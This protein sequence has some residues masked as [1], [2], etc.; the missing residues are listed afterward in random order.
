ME[1][2]RGDVSLRNKQSERSEGDADYAERKRR[3]T[4]TDSLGSCLD[5]SMESTDVYDTVKYEPSHLSAKHYDTDTTEPISYSL[6]SLEE[7]LSWKRSDANPFNVAT[8]PLANRQPPLTSMQR[9]TLVSHDMMGGYLDDRFVQGA[10]SETPYAFYHWQYI[11]IFNYFSHSMVTIPPVVWTNA[12]HKHGV[13]VLGTFITEWTDG[14][15]MCELILAGEESYRT[16]ADRLVQIAHCYGFDGWLVNIENP[17]SATAVKN[18]P[19]F[20]RYLTDQMHER[21][22]RSL[23]LWYDSVLDDG[24]LRWQNE[25]NDR[26]RQFFQACDGIFTNYNW[27]ERSLE[28]MSTYPEAQGRLG[29]VCSWG[30]DVFARGEVVGGKIIETNKALEVVRK[31]GFST[32]IFAPGWVHETQDKKEFRLNQDR[33]WGLLSDFLYVHRPS[34]LL[35]FVSSFCQG[36]GKSFYWRGKGESASSW[37]NLSAQE[38]QPLYLS[39]TLEGSGWLRT[40]GCPH[41]AWSGGSSLLVEGVIPSTLSKVCARIFSLHVP[42]ASRTLVSFVYKP[43]ESVRVALELQTTD[44][45]LCSSEPV[46]EVPHTS[47]QPQVLD[48]DHE[49]VR[50]FTES[51]GAWTLDGWTVR[52]LLLELRGC[53]LRDVSLNV[54]R[55]GGDQDVPFSCRIGE[56]VVMD[57]ESLTVPPLSVEDVCLS[58]ILWRRAVGRGEGPQEQ[59]HL[60]GTLRWRYPAPLARHFRVHWR[61]LRGPDPRTPPGPL[62]LVG[63]CYSSTFRVCELAVP[64]APAVLELLVEPVTREGFSVPEER[65]G[66]RVL[67]YV[68]GEGSSNA[69]GE[70]V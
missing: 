12:A 8:V 20:L 13:L 63:R 39:E 56:I 67:S 50:R 49:L 19:P 26:N 43:S 55:D 46:Q 18:T 16:A 42:L 24:A 41:E 35:P 66:R 4:E 2:I 5:Q 14:G 38:P 51:C 17:L 61:R 48:G 47:V 22:P 3:K 30:V 25:L 65:W 70:G 9:K 37:F 21:V 69:Q 29:D 32:A 1:H 6:K 58:D 23:V 68:Q 60:N 11:D 27:T 44:A 10:E 7:L 52:C 64:Q 34:S 45:A 59:L 53:A 36:F 57:A 40:R 54:S 28:W 31:H 62:G 15:Q 33:F